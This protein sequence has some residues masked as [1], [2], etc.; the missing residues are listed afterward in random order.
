MEIISSHYYRSKDVHVT[1]V[2]CEAGNENID[3]M[4]RR[5]KFDVVDSGDV[6][7]CISAMGKNGVDL[8]VVDGDVDGAVVKEYAGKVV[9]IECGYDKVED[10][11]LTTVDFFVVNGDGVT[12]KLLLSREVGG[13]SVNGGEAEVVGIVTRYMPAVIDGVL[14]I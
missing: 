12:S 2:I 14:N 3:R 9:F 7:E 10:G 1:T 4:S 8:V 11:W 5:Y 13:E 6:G